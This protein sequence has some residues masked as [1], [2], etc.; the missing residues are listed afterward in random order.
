MSSPGFNMSMQQVQHECTRLKACGEAAA[1][2]VALLGRDDKLRLVQ[3]VGWNGW[4]KQKGVYVGNILGVPRLGIPSINM[5]DAAGGFRT[6]MEE[7]VGTVP[8]WPSLLSMAA[9]FDLDVMRKF[10]LALGAEFAGKG[11]I[12]TQQTTC[13]TGAFEVTAGGQLIHSKLT[14][15][16]HGKCQTDEVCEPCPFRAINPRPRAQ[17][18]LVS[19]CAGAR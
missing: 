13:G 16:E 17:F 6:S 18:R 8:C 10:S 5:Q 19:G 2:L 7:I 12:S 9:T 3:G 14:V 11:A 4:V 1:Q 15:Q